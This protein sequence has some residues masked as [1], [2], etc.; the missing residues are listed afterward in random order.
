MRS[1]PIISFKNDDNLNTPL[2]KAIIENDFCLAQALCI[3]GSD[4]NAKNKQGLDAV[5]YACA[6]QN[7][8]IL[9]LLIHFGAK[10]SWRAEIALKILNP[11]PQHAREK[12]YS[13][14]T[15]KK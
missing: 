2:I 8:D 12:K 7:R 3:S 10:N 14:F 5:D 9:L 1:A 11:I 15:C 6:N 13:L 4:I